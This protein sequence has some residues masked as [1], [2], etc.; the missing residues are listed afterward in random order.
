MDRSRPSKPIL[1]AEDDFD[2]R[3]S[4]AGLFELDGYKVVTATDGDDALDRLRE[5]LDPC[6]ILLDLMM[7][8]KDGLQFRAEQLQDPRLASIP[9][10]AYSGYSSLRGRASA[11]GLGTFIQ[12]PVDFDTLL[13]IVERHCKPD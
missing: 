5:G 9:T 13:D 2:V 10:V 8:R 6:L 7:P 3:E 11:M 12:K 4:M 1:L